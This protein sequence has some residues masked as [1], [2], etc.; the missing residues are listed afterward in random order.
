MHACSH[1]RL[2]E[3]FVQRVSRYINQDLAADA[4]EMLK[5]ENISGNLEKLRRLKSLLSEESSSLLK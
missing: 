2:P 5:E 1:C 3:D 4:R